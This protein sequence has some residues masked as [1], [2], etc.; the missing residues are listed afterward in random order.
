MAIRYLQSVG[1]SCQTRHQIERFSS[2]PAIR[3]AGIEARSGPFDWIGAPP[4]RTARFIDAGLPA[5]EPGSVI[6][7][8]G[9]AFWTTPQFHA[10]HAFRIKEPAGKRLAIDET[11]DR[12]RAKFAHQREKFLETN[13]AETVFVLGNTQNN[14]VGAIYDPDEADEYCFD[15]AKIDVL[16]TSLDRLFGASCRLVV[17]SR[18]GRFDGNADADPRVRLIASEDSE[19]KGD[20]EAWREALSDFIGLAQPERLRLTA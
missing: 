7:R 3:E 13:P 6:D 2:H 4:V 14:V 5:Y 11:F 10:L 16:Q 18:A 20:D 12:E 15:S 19:W 1:M 17:I 8:R 9:N